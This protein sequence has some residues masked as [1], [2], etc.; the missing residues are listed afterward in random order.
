MRTKNMKPWR[1]AML[2][3][4][5]EKGRRPKDVVDE[6]LPLIDDP[7]TKLTIH[8]AADLMKRFPFSA[9]EIL[10]AFDRDPEEMREKGIGNLT[11]RAQV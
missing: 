10:Q 4:A 7:P 5:K 11:A 8:E 1:E 9:E 3:R 2:R 6:F